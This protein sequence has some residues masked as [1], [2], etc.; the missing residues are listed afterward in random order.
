MAQVAVEIATDLA[1]GTP[2]A[3]E[4]VL[5]AAQDALYNS[6]LYDEAVE[7]RDD[8]KDKVGKLTNEVELLSAVQINPDSAMG[9][10]HEE[11]L[12]KKAE[13]VYALS[14]QQDAAIEQVKN[15]K[16]IIDNVT[17]SLAKAR[18]AIDNQGKS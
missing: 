18:E 17:A 5:L 10:S 14:I 2:E 3:L 12:E 9:K 6:T 11:K 4:R 7:K 16:N 15:L 8:L 1:L 13:E